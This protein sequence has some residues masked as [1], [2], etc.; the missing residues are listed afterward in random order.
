MAFVTIFGNIETT[1]TVGNTG[2]STIRI[3]EPVSAKHPTT[4]GPQ[5]WDVEIPPQFRRLAERLSAGASIITI[6]EQTR[7]HFT[8]KGG[9][10]ATTLKNRLVR[11]R[12][13]PR[14][15]RG[16]KRAEQFDELRAEAET[17]DTTAYETD[18]DI[19]F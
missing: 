2:W 17:A 1:P 12:F 9:Y 8:G 3:V 16:E 7:D 18:A 4:R 11:L 10:P 5:Y 15:L 14:D 13:A 6:C 19:T